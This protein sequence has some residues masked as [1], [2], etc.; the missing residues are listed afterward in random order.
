MLLSDPL[1]NWSIDKR[2]I[3]SIIHFTR[4]NLIYIIFHARYPHL[5][6]AINVSIRGDYNL[7]SNTMHTLR[8]DQQIDRK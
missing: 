1:I 2:Q 6:R 8:S 7:I 4:S 3:T 5:K